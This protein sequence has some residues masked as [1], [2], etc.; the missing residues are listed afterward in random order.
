MKCLHKNEELFNDLVLETSN[1]YKISFDI[2]RH[3][4][5]VSYILK[6]IS[7]KIPNLIFK[8]GTS[9]TKCY[10]LINRY[11]EDIDLNCIQN[12]NLTNTK[13]KKFHHDIC[14]IIE[15]A[16]FKIENKESLRSGGK[17]NCIFAVI[18]E[19]ALFGKVKIETYLSL[20]SFPFV[21]LDVHSYLENYLNE[22]GRQDIIKNFE[23]HSF[24]INVQS[25]ERTF[26]DKLFAVCDY[27]ER[28]EDERNSRHLYDLHKLYKNIVFDNKFKKLFEKVREERKQGNN[29]IFISAQDDYNI[30]NALNMIIGK[31]FYKND[32]DKV[33]KLLLIEDIKYETV[34]NTLNLIK[35][36]IDKLYK[37]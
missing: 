32:F 13:L 28:N 7:N 36:D 20:R 10:Q 27:Y 2:V 15:S 29:N 5:Y 17:S 23:L 4:Y 22:I 1:Y 12:E 9:L 37:V 34:I 14:S 18:G 25:I 31:K 30:I 35:N 33:T 8:G 21:Q 11:S 3:D 16:G 26:I 24:K 19:G 6:E